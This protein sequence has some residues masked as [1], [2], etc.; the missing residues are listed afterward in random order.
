[1]KRKSTTGLLA[2]SDSTGS[3]SG[4]NLLLTPTPS[5]PQTRLE[6]DRFPNKKKM[7]KPTINAPNA[8]ATKH[9]RFVMPVPHQ[10]NS[11]FEVH[12]WWQEQIGQV[13]ENSSADE[14]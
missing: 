6:K 10:N 2:R 14:D 1:M 13:D 11:T 8:N 7:H 4:R 9:D 3:S 5:D 12:E